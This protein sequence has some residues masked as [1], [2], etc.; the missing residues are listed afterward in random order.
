MFTEHYFYFIFYFQAPIQE[1]N[2]NTPNLE[3]YSTMQYKIVSSYKIIDLQD[4]SC[5]LAK[6]NFGVSYTIKEIGTKQKK[7]EKQTVYYRK[8]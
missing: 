8:I 4:L 3:Q 5:V 1:F 6:Q 7:K 2:R